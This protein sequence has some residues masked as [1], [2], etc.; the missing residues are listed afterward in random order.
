LLSINM[1]SDKVRLISKALALLLPMI[2]K[3]AMQRVA[4]VYH[5]WT[6]KNMADSKN[7]VV[8]GGSFAGIQLVKRLA[9]SLPTG[10]KVVWIEKNSH[11]NYSFVFPRFSVMTQH[12]HTAFIPYDGVAKGAPAGIL[13]RIQDKA[14][15][16][17]GNQVQLA[18]GR[19]IDYAY[20]AIATG[21][22]QPLPV[23]VAA[24]ER[25]DA[26]EE[27]QGVQ[28]TI[29]ASHKIAVVGGGAVGVQL[30]SD[31][32]DFYPDKDVTLIHSHDHL[33]SHFGKRLGDYTLNTL[34]EEL[35]I[36]VLLNER[37]KMPAEG[38]FARSS[39]LVF[40]DGHGEKFDLIVSDS[41]SIGIREL[42][43]TP[44]VF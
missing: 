34:E 2:G 12:E 32:K 16:L 39:T 42:S 18:S 29:K 35:K 14:I 17:T 38:N 37:P 33:M 36:R 4:A 28:E 10:S 15:G 21:S 5:S 7:V 13:T 40:S 19:K 27:L 41:S 23:Q 26:C 3:M 11:F 30:S 20:V 9:E 6:W 24:T 43:I 31:I 22:S 25:E 44:S 1:A 8:I